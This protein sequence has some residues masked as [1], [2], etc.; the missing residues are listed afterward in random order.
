MVGPKKSVAE[1]SCRVK[2]NRDGVN[3]VAGFGERCW[4]PLP[5]RRRGKDKD[6]SDDSE[7]EEV[8]FRELRAE[9]KTTLS[10]RC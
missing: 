3:I 10:I 2:A 6:D 4:D 9:G 5:T 8:R 1:L 7:P